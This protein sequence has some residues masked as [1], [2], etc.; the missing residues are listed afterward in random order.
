[1]DDLT[2]LVARLQQE[3]LWRA[4]LGSHELFHS[5]MLEYLATAFPSE[6]DVV[7]RLEADSSAGLG[8]VLRERRHLDLVVDL[9][10]R[11]PV[12]IENKLFDVPDPRQLEGY[13]RNIQS[14]SLRDPSLVLLSLMGET[15]PPDRGARW[16]YLSYG[17]LGRRLGD[18]F[19]PGGGFA[20]QLM[21]HWG[22][23][24]ST[25][26]ELATVLGLTDDP[27]ELFELRLSPGERESVASARLAPF[28]AKLRS[29]QLLGRIQHALGDVG[30]RAS[31]V[32]GYTNGSGLV[33]GFV[34]VAPG[35]EVGWQLQGSQWRLAV[36]FAPG[37][38]LHGRGA[39]MRGRR[40]DYV[41]EH[42]AD[43]FDFDVVRDVG[44]A[45]AGK[46]SRLEFLH[47]APDFVYRR[48]QLADPTV[49]QLENLVVRT[50]R[51]LLTRPPAT[52]ET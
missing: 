23:L 6:A 40:E 14:L 47:F 8:S 42:Y 28:T 35:E 13:A 45:L 20:E 30:A 33:E 1:M 2:A 11:R 38:P 17:E 10:G 31:L 50:T 16:S 49:D 24:C 25:L 3:P 32:A 34:S 29:Y 44:I 48:R 18:A 26:Q 52:R 12:V 22:G 27:E 37:T 9:P 19:D 21:V 36:R 51:P 5:N 4:A 39:A 15:Q 46:P 43:H 41:R 7:L